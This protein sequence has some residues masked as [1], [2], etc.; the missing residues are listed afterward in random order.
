MML[1]ILQGLVIMSLM[2]VIS[3]TYQQ[4]AYHK[5]QFKC[6]FLMH[7]DLVLMIQKLLKQKKNRVTLKYRTIDRANPTL[8]KGI[9]LIILPN[10]Q[11]MSFGKKLQV[12]SKKQCVFWNYRK[13]NQVRER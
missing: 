12:Q 7:Q 13:E 2:S 11:A 10:Q 6:L 3:L 8:V 4:R 1:L 9:F 5:Q